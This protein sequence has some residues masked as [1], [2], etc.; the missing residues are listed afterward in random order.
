MIEIVQTMQHQASLLP[1][2]GVRVSVMFHL[3]C[4]HIIFI[5]VLEIAAHSVDHMFS[6]Y[7]D[8]CNFSYFPFWFWRLDLGSDCF[9]S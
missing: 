8:Y 1:V 6:L 4:V 9:S 5:F 7:F 2:F 3:T